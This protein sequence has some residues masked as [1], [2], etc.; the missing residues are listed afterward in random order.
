MVDNLNT[1]SPTL[2]DLYP[3]NAIRDLTAQ[4]RP[5]M[6]WV[7][8]NENFVGEQ[9][10]V[11][12]KYAN[13][14]GRSK[15]FGTAVSNKGSTKEKA[16]FVKRIDD[17]SL[18][19]ISNE[20]IEA[21]R[22]GEGSFVDQ[23]SHKTEA[24]IN[25]LADA[26]HE[27]LFKNQGAS[28]GQVG[29]IN[30]TELTLKNPN[31][32][33]YFEDG[34]VVQG[35]STDGTSGSVHSGSVT[36]TRVNR[37]SGV[38][39]ASANW[40]SGISSLV[41]DDYLFQ[42]GDFGNGMAGLDAWLPL[43]PPSAGDN[44]FQVDRS[45][46]PSRLAGVRV[47]AADV[48]GAEIHEKIVEGIGRLRREGNGARP[49]TITV[50]ENTYARLVLELQEQGRYTPPKGGVVGF[51]ELSFVFPGTSAM[52]LPDHRC[53]D[54]RIYLLKKDTWELAS[55]NA[56]PFI[57][58]R[59]APLIREATADAFEVRI[60]FYGNLVCYAPGHNCVIDNS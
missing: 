32:V 31:D 13:P 41:A 18:V 45:D 24:G 46:D 7:P 19:S 29:S 25:S 44:F 57:T 34:M 2:K 55:L 14:Q 58:N 28:K 20:L 37:A 56:A 16:F 5:L 10:K 50:S 17:H 3:E 49:D 15:T 35:A 48:A 1:A 54:N 59:D 60:A 33:V 4:A 30:G 22:R 42:D 23:L 47:T 12:V 9:M 8:K 40:T 51:N 21:G 43:V 6:A 36:I 53:P 39:T 27:G 26:I 38:L 11:P 52:V